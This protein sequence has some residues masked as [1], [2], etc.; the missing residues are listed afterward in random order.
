MATAAAPEAVPW[1]YERLGGGNVAT[2]GW[3]AQ[4]GTGSPFPPYSSEHIGRIPDW[5]SDANPG[6]GAYDMNQAWGSEAPNPLNR[7][8]LGG[9]VL[10]GAMGVPPNPSAPTTDVGGTIDLEY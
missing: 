7:A 4:S 1:S 6:A 2:P 9:D 5:D 3:T 10:D 8:P